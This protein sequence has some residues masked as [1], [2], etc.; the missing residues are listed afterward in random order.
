MPTCYGVILIGF[1]LL[2]VGGCSSE[3]KFSP[4]TLLVAKL[5]QPYSARIALPPGRQFFAIVFMYQ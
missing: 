2:I 5:G 1:S 4:D 3:D